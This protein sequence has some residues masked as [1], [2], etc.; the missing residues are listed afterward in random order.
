MICDVNIYTDIETVEKNVERLQK[1]IVLNTKSVKVW[2][3][4]LQN[5]EHIYMHEFLSSNVENMHL[6]M[7]KI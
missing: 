2:S 6:K 5:K 1:T 3:K 7:E 4:I